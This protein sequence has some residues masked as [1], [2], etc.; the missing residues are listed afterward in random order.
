MY[1][2][3]IPIYI[4]FHVYFSLDMRTV[5]GDMMLQRTKNITSSQDLSVISFECEQCEYVSFEIPR[6]KHAFGILV[7]FYVHQTID[8]YF[9]IL[10]DSKKFLKYILLKINND[11][12]TMR[13]PIS[14]KV[15]SLR[16]CYLR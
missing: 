7:I 8:I 6:S 16:L 12:S 4:L 14:I 5:S 13:I 2:I 10:N 11:S 9:M 15:L 3:Y 1:K